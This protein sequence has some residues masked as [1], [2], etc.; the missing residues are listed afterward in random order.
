MCE[1]TAIVPIAGHF[2]MTAILEAQCSMVEFIRVPVYA[3]TIV[4]YKVRDLWKLICDV[5]DI[6]RLSRHN[7]EAD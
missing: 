3:C 7:S 5:A 4:D 1:S 6:Y 2:R